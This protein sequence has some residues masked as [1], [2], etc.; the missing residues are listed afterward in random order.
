[1][2]I[3]VSEDSRGLTLVIPSAVAAGAAIV[4]DSEVEVT[5]ENGAV[6]VRPMTLPTYSLQELLA[7]VTAENRHAETNW[8]PAVGNETW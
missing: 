6:V 4:A 1:M 8:G 3:R 5:V 7:G 2:Q